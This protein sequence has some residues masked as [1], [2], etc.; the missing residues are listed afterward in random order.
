MA[1]LPSQHCHHDVVGAGGQVHDPVRGDVGRLPQQLLVALG[2]LPAVRDAGEGDG[3]VLPEVLPHVR[4][5]DAVTGHDAGVLDAQGH[6]RRAAAEAAHVQVA[7]AVVHG[8]DLGQRRQRL[9]PRTPRGVHGDEAVDAAYGHRALLGPVASAHVVG[10]PGA[11][12]LVL[13]EA[14]GVFAG[15]A[16]GGA[17]GVAGVAAADGDEDE[18]DGAADGGVGAVTRAEHAGVA[19]DA[20]LVPDRA[21]D[22]QRRPH[23]SGGGLDAVEVE[24]GLHDAL[25]RGDDHRQV[26][27]QATRH[28]AVDRDLL[29]RGRGPLGRYLSDDLLWVPVR[30]REHALHPLPGGGHDGQPVAEL[31]FAEP[32]VGRLQG[33]LHLDDL[34]DEGDLETRLRL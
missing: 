26:F 25:H 3:R 18:A 24:A 21:V 29:H 12:L 16:E 20:Q 14:E 2:P 15:P 23:V 33:V 9:L 31:P 19:V 4:P 5:G 8:D 7:A 6:Q 13:A 17:V 1:V 10:L 11:P 22:Q 34:G 30:A 28:H 32:V 27:R